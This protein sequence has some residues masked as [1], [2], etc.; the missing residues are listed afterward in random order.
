MLTRHRMLVLPG[1]LLNYNDQSDIKEQAGLSS[2]T[3]REAH[4]RLIAE[5]VREMTARPDVGAPRDDHQPTPSC[6]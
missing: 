3:N 6:R 2:L 5:S 4:A 1:P